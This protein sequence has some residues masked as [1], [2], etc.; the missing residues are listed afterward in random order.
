VFAVLLIVY[1]GICGLVDSLSWKL[2]VWKYDASV[3]IQIVLYCFWTIHSGYFVIHP[4][5][6]FIWSKIA[7]YNWLEQQVVLLN[8]N[9]YSVTDRLK[10]VHIKW[11][12]SRYRCEF[13]VFDNGV[14]ENSVLLRYD[15]A[16]PG[17]QFPTFRRN[18][19]PSSLTI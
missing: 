5:H 4:L 6:Q 14:V 8:V 11:V 15:V 18:V 13:W 1:V 3:Q 16:L 9:W 12:N 7:K 2:A 19:V 10:L 17:T